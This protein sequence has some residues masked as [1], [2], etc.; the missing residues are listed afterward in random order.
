MG[1]TASL[2]F[3]PLAT[4]VVAFCPQVCVR[5]CVSRVCKGCFLPTG[6]CVHVCVCLEYAVAALYLQVCVCN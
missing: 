2:L 4:A 3:S 5:V 1:A 6:V